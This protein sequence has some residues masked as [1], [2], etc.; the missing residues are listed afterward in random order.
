MNLL[1]AVKFPFISVAKQIAVER[2]IPINEHTLEAGAKR[3]LNALKGIEKKTSIDEEGML[4]ELASYASARILLSYMKNSYL[5]RKFAVSEA[6]R[7]WKLLSREEERTIRDI[8]KELGLTL[9]KHLERA[10]VKIPQYLRYSPKS[11]YFF[12]VSRNVKEGYVDV[13]RK[14]GQDRFPGERDYLRLVQ[15]AIRERVEEIP[16]PPHLPSLEIYAKKIMTQ[17]PKT[18]F[19]QIKIKKG[20]NPPCMEV[21]WDDILKHKNLSHNPRWIFAVYLI[22][23]GTPIDKVVSL[24]SNLPDFEEKKTRYQL[25]HIKKRGYSVPSC[26]TI[27]SYGLCVA[28]CRIKSPMGWF[29]KWKKQE[30]K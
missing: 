18:E 9:E 15:E 22:K 20:N 25:E 3:I 16:N 8:G 23:T 6:K 2:N 13:E 5:T 11:D 1:F 14:G 26:Q 7:A 4:M 24:Y 19:P 10:V 30:K 29:R 28:N 17:L 12:L 27:M 21:I